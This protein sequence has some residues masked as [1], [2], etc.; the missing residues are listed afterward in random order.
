MKARIFKKITLFIG[1]ILILF[2]LSA[3]LALAEGYLEPTATVS[4]HGGYTTTTNK[5]KYCHAVHLAEGSFMLTRANTV[6]ESCDYCH[7]DGSGAGTIIVSNY[8]GHTMG[9]NTVYLGEAPGGID[10][11]KY[12]STNTSPFTCLT[13]HSVH[14]NIERIVVLS[15][16]D[17]NYLLVNNPDGTG[18]ALSSSNTLAEWCADCHPLML[19][20][21]EESKLVN[22]IPVYSHASSRTAV[23]TP[24]IDASDGKN[25]GP[26]C[27][28]C[29]LSSLFPHGQGGTG[30]DMLKDSFDGISLDNVCNDCH[31]ESELP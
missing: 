15:D 16:L 18:T 31:N 4:P 26:S 30:R 25:Y 23:T 21:N 28:Q 20:S 5:C 22:N 7:G 11:H 19:G 24:V 2:G 29:H 27:R 10:G 12:Y 14:G 13:C 17:K 1:L 3:A 8:E 9:K 6:Y